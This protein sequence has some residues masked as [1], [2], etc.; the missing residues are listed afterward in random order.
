MKKER[1]VKTYGN[2]RMVQ[3][4]L[5]VGS[6]IILDFLSDWN[7]RKHNSKFVAFLPENVTFIN[8]TI[9][10]RML[11]WPVLISFFVPVIFLYW[12]QKEG[13]HAFQYEMFRSAG[14]VTL[15]LS[16]VIIIWLAG[17][18]RRTAITLCQ[19]NSLYQLKIKREARSFCGRR[20]NKKETI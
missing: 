18:L 6:N 20:M 9:F 11:L 4:F 1:Q 19:L 8:D 7:D 13:R 17:A 10:M 16:A 2:I 5:S 15:M 14:F 12:Q 3:L